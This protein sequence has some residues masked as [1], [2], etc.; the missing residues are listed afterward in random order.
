MQEEGP[1]EAFEKKRPVVIRKIEINSLATNVISLAVKAS[2]RTKQIFSRG[3]F[4]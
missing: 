2:V 3:F 4:L 1:N